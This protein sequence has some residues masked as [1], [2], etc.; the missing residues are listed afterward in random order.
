MIGNIEKREWQ[1]NDKDKKTNRR[2][3]LCVFA[4]VLAALI[5]VTNFGFAWAETTSNTN[6][7]LASDDIKKNPTAMKILEN[8]ELF[9]QRYAAM[10]QRQQLVDQQNQFIEQQRKIANQYLQTDLAGINNGNDLNTPRNAYAAFVTHVGDS[11]QGLFWDQF[12]FMQEKVH[13]AR[14]AMNK[15]L[16]NGGT[17]EQALQA[18]NNEASI[19]K[20]QLVSINK[21]LNIKYH[22]ADAKV[23]SLF[24]KDGNLHRNA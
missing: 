2:I 11:T 1:A 15:V 20:D 22:L 13:N 23:Q 14:E 6:T 7:I 8:I 12:S 4:S 19:H 9:K 5:V 16:K 24:N 21:N 18:Y 10:Q 17:M 3:Q